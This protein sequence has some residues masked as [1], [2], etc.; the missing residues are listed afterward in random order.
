MEAKDRG[1]QREIR[2]C[3]RSL[4]AHLQS[5]Q[6]DWQVVQQVIT[7]TGGLPLVANLRNGLWYAPPSDFSANCYFKSTDGHVSQWKFSLSRINL[8]IA[9]L[10][11]E[12]GG[13]IIVDS[14]R[15]GKKFPDALYATLPIWM[16]VLNSL[17]FPSHE[18]SELFHSP[19]WMPPSI[20]SQIIQLLPSLVASIPQ[21]QRNIIRDALCEKLIC[22]LRPIWV[23]PDR[24][25][26]LE[27]HG[28]IAESFLEAGGDCSG[29]GVINTKA[30]ERTVPIILLCCSRDIDPQDQEQHYSWE[31]IKGAGDDEENWARGLTP[32]VFWAHIDDILSPVIDS[33]GTEEVVD[34]LVSQVCHREQETPNSSIKV[35]KMNF[36]FCSY[37]S[38]F[39]EEK[40]FYV[41]ADNNALNDK[42]ILLH[43]SDMGERKM[44]LMDAL[45]SRGG[46]FIKIEM[47]TGKRDHPKDYWI[48]NV[49]PQCIEFVLA[50]KGELNEIGGNV[51]LC[52]DASEP[53]HLGACAVILVALIIKWRGDNE[54]SGHEGSRKDLYKTI[55]L[56]IQTVHPNINPARR[57]M[58]ELCLYFDDYKNKKSFTNYDT[59]TKAPPQKEN[60][61]MNLNSYERTFPDIRLTYL[62]IPG[63]AEP[64]RLCLKLGGI[65]FI[66][67]RVSY[68]EIRQMRE[69]GE[70]PWSQVPILEVDGETYGQSVA[71]LRWAGRK[72]GLFPDA[73]QLR[74]DSMIE[75]IGDIHKA[76]IPQW[77][78]HAVGRSPV[79]G[80]FYEETKLTEE[81]QAGVLNAL[82][83]DIIKFR[84]ELI[85]RCHIERF[86]APRFLCGDMITIADLMLYTLVTGLRDE[87][88]SFCPGVSSATVL[89]GR[90]KLLDLV[91]RICNKI[92]E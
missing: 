35:G 69:K 89:E 70:L 46:K 50:L 66:D 90:T 25:G 21:A 26:V 28:D 53:H 80:S 65:E 64:I 10:A 14:T 78:H 68:E 40:S 84:F 54:V 15:R 30:N 43:N 72:T 88:N 51:F 1:I 5:I 59:S 8:H 71:I 45:R 58:K 32:S 55:L 81:Q 44:E 29:Y 85:E 52:Y 27:W 74:V 61:S 75:A 31:Y 12:K 36:F 82:N 76:M 20:R 4:R 42:Y 48:E 47:K 9:K 24:D 16:A 62:D 83:N 2:A 57:F 41:G 60:S 23:V 38:F 39:S 37:D 22:P 86:K 13:C 17:L 11:A 91:E 63:F 18:T 6:S 67:R 19:P 92:E 3:R 77:Y 56:E 33:N 73:I 87:E 34:R 7:V 79:D 49:F